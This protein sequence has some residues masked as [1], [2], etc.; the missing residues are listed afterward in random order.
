MT[1]LGRTGRAVAATAVFLT[2]CATDAPPPPAPPVEIGDTGIV[3]ILGDAPY[4][5]YKEEG[6]GIVIDPNGLVLTVFHVVE[7]A[8]ALDVLVP[9]TGREYRAKVLGY[10]RT[11]DVALISLADAHGLATAPLGD[12]STVESGDRVIAR[13]SAAGVGR[14]LTRTEGEVIA[15]DAEAFVDGVHRPGCIATDAVT[16]HGDSGG[17]LFGTTGTVIGLNDAANSERA[18]AVPIDKAMA[19]A[20]SILA[21]TPTPSVHVGPPATL[22]VGFGMPEFDTARTGF[23]V[24]VRE[25]FPGQ[26]AEA[27]GIETGDVIVAIDGAPVTSWLSLLTLL[28]RHTV[29]DVVDVTWLDHALASRT[30]AVTL[31][32]GRDGSRLPELVGPAAS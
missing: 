21:R 30:A 28:D 27:A 22:G 29:G 16:D 12:S 1:T 20:D 4:G 9:E 19:I 13:G 14:P 31:V 3:Q 2:A 32:A 25:V 11:A 24:L 15:L 8:N 17:P 18:F 26:P 7:E 6:A 5:G 10:D 23:G